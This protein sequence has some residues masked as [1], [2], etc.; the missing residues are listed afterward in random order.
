VRFSLGLLQQTLSPMHCVPYSLP[1]PVFQVVQITAIARTPFSMS[2]PFSFALLMPKGALSHACVH[3]AEVFFKVDGCVRAVGFI[4]PSSC[5]FPSPPPPP[6][7]AHLF[8]SLNIA[9][10]V[11]PRCEK[12]SL[13]S[14]CRS[15]RDFFFL[16]VS[17]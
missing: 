3:L 9:V 11:T 12:N 10:P 5:P 17:L 16:G 4:D 1:R 8:S 7:R 13:D 14:V 2:C 15:P 6:L